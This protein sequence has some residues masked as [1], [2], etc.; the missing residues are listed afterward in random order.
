[1]VASIKLFNRSI[2]NMAIDKT[3]L[4]EMHDTRQKIT[5]K[6]AHLQDRASDLAG[7]LDE[8]L[9]EIE[10]LRDIMKELK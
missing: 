6:L 1:M 2:Y 3:A 5:A 8:V 9:T 4:E 7:E 10:I